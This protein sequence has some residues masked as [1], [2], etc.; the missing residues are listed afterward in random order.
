MSR[1]RRLFIL[2]QLTQ[3][4][5]GPRFK[6]TTD[7][8]RELWER[9]CCVR[10]GRGKTG[11]VHNLFPMKFLWPVVLAS[12]SP[13]RQELLRRIVAEFEVDSA[14][15]DETPQPEETPWST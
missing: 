3:S 8:G 12:A 11:A 15:I 9:W 13:R 14:D 1:L 2:A 6:L 4:A 7:S 10:H 5:L